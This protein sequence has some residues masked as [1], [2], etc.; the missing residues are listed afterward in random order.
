MRVHPVPPC[1]CAAYNVRAAGDGG[2]G[3]EERSLTASATL[4]RVFALRTT[5]PGTF[6]LI[7]VAL[8]AMLLVTMQAP[9]ASADEGDRPHDAG[10]PETTR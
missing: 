1:A 6:A 7:V 3:C 4:A 8:V 5:A 9:T 10:R 2:T